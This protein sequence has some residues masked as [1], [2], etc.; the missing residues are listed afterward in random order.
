MMGTSPLLSLL[1]QPDLLTFCS[2]FPSPHS[3]LPIHIYHSPLPLYFTSTHFSPTF[4][5]LLQTFSPTAGRQFE[6]KNQQNLTP[7][8]KSTYSKFLKPPLIFSFLKPAPPPPNYLLFIF[9]I[10]PSSLHRILLLLLLL[11]L[12]L[13]PL[14]LR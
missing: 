14:F 11:L 2:Y 8:K 7:L 9:P 6:E 10:S 1:S 12:H 5:P 13:L 3:P 4:A